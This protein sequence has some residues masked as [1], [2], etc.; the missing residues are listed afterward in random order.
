L[1][2]V[3][4]VDSYGPLPAAYNGSTLQVSYYCEFTGR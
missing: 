2:A 1:R 3:Q 4:R